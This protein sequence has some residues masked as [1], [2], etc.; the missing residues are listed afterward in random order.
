MHQTSYI[1]DQKNSTNSV[2]SVPARGQGLDI[3][4]IIDRRRECSNIRDHRCSG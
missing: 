3:K 4:L 2:R 1:V